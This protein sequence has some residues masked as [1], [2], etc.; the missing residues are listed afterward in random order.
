MKE[1][2]RHEQLTPVTWSDMQ[3]ALDKKQ[4]TLLPDDLV[5]VGEAE[6][7]CE[8]DS[9]CDGYY[10]FTVIRL[11]LETKAEMNQRIKDEKALKQVAQ[12]NRY[13]LHLTLMK[14]FEGGNN[15]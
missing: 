6:G 5:L 4:T 9:Q 3:I 11:V 7:W 12:E 2:I 1:I 13:Q 14:E 8:T 10:Y 15:E